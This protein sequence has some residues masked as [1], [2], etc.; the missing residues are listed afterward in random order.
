M[1]FIFK[2]KYTFCFFLI[3]YDNENALISKKD[4]ASHHHTVV[5]VSCPQRAVIP[6]HTAC[7]TRIEINSTTHHTRV[8]TMADLSPSTCRILNLAKT[9]TN[10]FNTAAV[11]H[12]HCHRIWAAPL[13]IKTHR[14]HRIPVVVTLVHLTDTIPIIIT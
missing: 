8:H 12:H 4:I 6:I 10:T 11:Y 1:R 3:I 5:D 7:Q 13:T 14:I 9:I 2:I